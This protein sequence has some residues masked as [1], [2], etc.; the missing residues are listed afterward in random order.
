[1]RGPCPAA[2]RRQTA[3]AA[4]ADA[5]GRQPAAFLTIAEA[6]QL[7]MRA[8][9]AAAILKETGAATAGLANHGGALRARARVQSRGG[10][11]VIDVERQFA[12]LEIGGVRIRRRGRR[13]AEA[14]AN[15][16]APNDAAEAG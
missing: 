9:R 8:A 6:H 11:V 1:M 4:R 16:I 13:A 7:R 3:S 15:G 10:D 12:R 2:W 5:V 14:A